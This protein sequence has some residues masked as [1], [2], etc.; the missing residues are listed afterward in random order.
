[1]GNTAETALLKQCVRTAESTAGEHCIVCHLVGPLDVQ[2]APQ[3]VPM[4]GVE[5]PFLFGVQS[6]RLTAIQQGNENAG[7]VDG[8]FV[9]Q[10]QCAVF[11]YTL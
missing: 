9:V 6:P 11:P 10:C 5:S 1:M 2:D 3:A 4:E 7:P 8:C